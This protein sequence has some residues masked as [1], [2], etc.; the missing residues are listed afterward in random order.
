MRLFGAA[1]T[2]LSSWDRFVVALPFTK[3]VFV[4]GE[5]IHVGAEARARRWTRRG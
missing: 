3:G 5:P 2:L 1:A 4:W